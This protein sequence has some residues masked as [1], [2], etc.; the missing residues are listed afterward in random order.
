[1]WFIDPQ[2]QHNLKPDRNAESQAPPQSTESKYAFNKI[3]REF[4]CKL[5]FEKHKD[6]RIIWFSVRK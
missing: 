5:K 1:M 3:P 6:R 2:Y 4:T